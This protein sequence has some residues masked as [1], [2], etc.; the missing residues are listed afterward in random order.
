[1]P[2]HQDSRVIRSSRDDA[3]KYPSLF[4]VWRDS[5]PSQK[6]RNEVLAQW[7]DIARCFAFNIS[8]YTV[9]CRPSDRK[10]SCCRVEVLP[11]QTDDLTDAK[12]QIARELCHQKKR[13]FEI[14]ADNQ[15]LLRREN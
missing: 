1:M 8:N 12:A 7:D 10:S 2:A 6:E 13:I 9:D 4:G 3:W 15:H 14:L 5:L 11:H